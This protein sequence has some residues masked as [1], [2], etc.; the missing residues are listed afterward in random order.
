MADA[1]PLAPR[2][3]GKPS[4]RPAGQA[5]ARAMPAPAPARAPRWSPGLGFWAAG[6]A[7]ALSALGLLGA[8]LDVA[9]GWGVEDFLGWTDT[10]ED[11]PLELLL[12]LW[13]QSGRTPAAWLYL[14]L[15]SVL[16]VPLYGGL[17]LALALRQAQALGADK[18][19]RRAQRERVALSVLVPPAL[20]LVLV[21]LLE[22]AL[23][24]ARVGELGPWLAL[25]CTALGAAAL[26]AS[27]TR[28][29]PGLR[30]VRQDVWVTLG[31]AAAGLLLMGFGS[32]SCTPRGPWLAQLGCGAH[33]SKA[34]LA[35]VVVLL[36]AATALAWLMG[37]AL[38]A[39]AP[40]A[41]RT[42]RAQLRAAVADIV[43]RSRGVL[44]ALAALAALLL[45]TG[46]AGD[47]LYATAVSPFR[48]SHAGLAERLLRTLGMVGG[49]ALTGL[50]LWLLVHACWL[51]TRAA[52]QL[53]RPH[54]P[55]PWPGS[56]PPGQAVARIWARML[57]L[58]PALLMA[59]ATAQ[60]VRET[61][62][63]QAL[64]ATAPWPVPV[65]LLVLFG[66]A[67]LALGGG[68]LLRRH[69]AAEV[70][71]YDAFTWPALA[72][73]AGV[74]AAPD[75]PALPAPKYRFCNLLPPQALA[76]LL[77]GLLLGCRVLDLLPGP[78]NAGPLD[79]LPSLA[80]PAALLTLALWLCVL[81]ALSL[82]E[83]ASARPWSGVLLLALLGLAWAGWSANAAVWPAV[84]PEGAAAAGGLRMLGFTVLLGGVLLLAH[85]LA[86]REARRHALARAD[87]PRR[88]LG[89]TAALTAAGLWAL[90]LLV[91]LG[92][93][94]GASARMPA[95][96]EA[97]AQTDRRPT[98]DAAL[99]A[100]LHSLCGH[101]GA[102]PA[103][104]GTGADPADAPACTPALALD[105]HGALRVYLAAGDGAG[106]RA[107]AWTALALQQLN[108][109]DAQ[110]LRRTFAITGA[111]G[112][113][114]G[115]A[116]TRACAVDGHIDEDC[117]LAFARADL[118]SPLLSA[119]L[120]E[121]ALAWLL[122]T[123]W[124]GLPGCG[125]LSRAA[126]FEQ[127]LESASPGLRLG[128]ME[129]R[130]QALSY[131][132]DHLPY[133]LLQAQWLET[134]ERA[135]A[136]DLR[137]AWT[138]FPGAHDPLELTGL[139]LPL[140]TAAHNAARAAPLHPPGAL[141][142]SRERCRDRS[143]SP[144]E[145]AAS[146]APRAHDPP[147]PVCGHLGDGGSADPG[148]AQ[149]MLDL[150][151]GLSHCLSG[152]AAGR[153]G[154]PHCAA[155]GE[156]RL[157]W[158]RAHLLPQLL[159]VR[160]DEA[161]P[162]PVNGQCPAPEQRAPDTLQL[163]MAQPVAGC[164]VPAGDAHEP[165][166]PLCQAPAPAARWP[167]LQP[168]RPAQAQAAAALAE[169]RLAQALATLRADLGG[170]ARD[171]AEPALRLLALHPD[172]L[173]YGSGWLLPALAVERL[174]RQAAACMGAPAP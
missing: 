70:L 135:I 16:L 106:L 169:S 23:G 87:A 108:Q 13:D 100:W 47:A 74:V 140:G 33:A 134:G 142:G 97:V 1:K 35:G 44:L 109:R 18:A 90:A 52:C 93:D 127:A 63:V 58:A 121:D 89:A 62:R 128:L 20:A 172:G 61:V 131:P 48:A 29:Q 57:G 21:D 55:A 117:V 101:G 110:W 132:G 122:P 148:G 71:C 143:A 10:A 84:D 116:L 162:A 43:L 144:A 129:S 96:A 92:A 26:Y 12:R 124:C 51:W 151:Q 56:T 46:V 9:G 126:W 98:L 53:R 158:L 105:A 27:A 54:S 15:D 11:G 94:H 133:L 138:D 139:D 152:N 83:L 171:S 112:A 77:L 6:T 60:T 157:A 167:W 155:L 166:R 66:L 80:L 28:R 119:G 114:V 14:G 36:H 42:Q 59:A 85:T 115:A 113:G 146:D 25:G 24:L 102:A 120:F 72:A 99:A 75:A 161:P 123:R 49:F 30:L 39:E 64:G 34:W 141:R 79:V 154:W 163:A 31:L 4:P 5:Q 19:G 104:A 81:G 65:V 150:L 130:R 17:L 76:P 37:V 137:I 153:E 174:Q 69:L 45:G 95:G 86:L 118:Q 159:L 149:A 7:L 107:A 2:R 40:A 73:R 103:S 125:V 78:S 50:A 165:R 173:R 3:A 32:P 41:Q 147:G 170:V 8:V 136:S 22:N 67:A 168:Q 88:P 68:F 156:A 111:G 91:L 160:A 38:P 164:A 145:A 82:F